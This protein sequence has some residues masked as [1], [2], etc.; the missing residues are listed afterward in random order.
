MDTY[1]IISTVFAC[2]VF[3]AY[4]N[5]RFFQWQITIAVMIGSLGCSCVII[6]LQHTALA[7][8]AQKV[9]Q[10]ISQINFHEILMKGMLSVL[11]FAGAMT[12]DFS[13]IRAQLLEISILSSIGTIL[14]TLIIA[15]VT[16]LVMPLLGFHLPLIYC[17]LFGALISPT[18]PIAVLA[19][20]KNLN[21]PKNITTILCGESLFNDGVAIV[22]FLT[23]YQLNFNNIPITLTSIT[24]LFCKKAMGGML[25]GCALGYGA[26]KL[27][28]Q[29][30]QTVAT[31]ITLAIVTSGYSLANNFH[32]S[33]PLAM[34]V[35]GVFIGN[36][37]HTR[38]E[39]HI[40][41]QLKAFWE[42]IDEL[43]NAVLFLLIGFELVIVP[44][45]ISHVL[46]SFFAIVLVLLTRFIT[47]ALPFRFIKTPFTNNIANIKILTWGGL[48]GGLAVALALSLPDSA[49]RN[50]ILILTF[51]VVMFSIIVQGMTI[52][53][54]LNKN[55]PP[56]NT[57]EPESNELNKA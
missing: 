5:Q 51:S 53:V 8:Q 30:N 31:L 11:L 23:L 18:D 12:L 54:L 41:R 29:S 28:L 38:L 16:D 46:A 9:T 19:T 14:S 26:N 25:F 39:N 20:F 42:I 33:G 32:L 57:N 15:L 48:R 6:L 17:F 50:F 40:I 37:A 43:F 55:L 1:T 44:L 13:R 35:A 7:P 3:F 2:V 21:A 24:L 10:V 4:L 56:N 52:P 36:T 45:N 34:V 47:V 22:I 27:I 49:S